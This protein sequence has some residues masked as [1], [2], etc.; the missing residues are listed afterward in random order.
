[1][2]IAV[3]LGRKATKKQTKKNTHDTVVNS[4]YPDEMSHNAA[5]HLGPHCL[6]R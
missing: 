1:M 4:E 3:D 6:L 2:T 5:F